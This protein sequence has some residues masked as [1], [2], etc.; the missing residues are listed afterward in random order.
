M[1]RVQTGD[2][3]AYRAL[4]E[5]IQPLIRGMLRRWF[6]DAEELA[7]AGQETLLT[8]HRARHTYDPTRPFER[9]LGALARHT[10]A[11][12]LRRKMRRLRLEVGV[13][14]VADL[15]I[16]P[17]TG[18]PSELERAIGALPAAQRDAFEMVKVD[19]LSFEQAAARSGTTVGALKVRAH[20]AY[21]SIKAAL[22]R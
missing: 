7:D 17:A 10:A 14:M 20:R 15:P 13:D 1:E 18:G 9:W 12:L 11:D 22:A 16:E 8:L 3:D 2:G 21:K 5:D 6:A 4:L 19:G